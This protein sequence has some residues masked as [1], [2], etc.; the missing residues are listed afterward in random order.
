M[1]AVL[2]MKA[3][4]YLAQRIRRGISCQELARC[5]PGARA[6]PFCRRS[7]LAADQ[8]VR[9]SCRDRC[10]PSGREDRPQHLRPVRRTPRA[11]RLRR[12]VGRAGFEDP[13]H[14]RH[15]QRRRRR[16]QG[17]QGAERALARRLLRRRVSLAQWHR[18]ARPAAGHAESQ[19]GRRHRAEHLRHARVH[20]LRRSRSAPTPIY[21]STWARA[22]RPKRPTGWNT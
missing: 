4:G 18:S 16:A 8:R 12:R 17:P 9:S 21:P 19:L 11:R 6:S 22:R 14:A 3:R 1:K 10:R 7:F 2:P 15:P 13:E 5:S 20:G